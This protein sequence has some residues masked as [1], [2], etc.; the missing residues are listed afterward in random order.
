[1]PAY[2]T[3]PAFRIPKWIEDTVFTR[4]DVH[5]TA[6]AVNQV[7]KIKHRLRQ[8]KNEP[9]EFIKGMHSCLNMHS[10]WCAWSS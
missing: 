3:V 9:E 8:Y 1:M 10:S 2:D 5:I 7:S 6:E 4:N